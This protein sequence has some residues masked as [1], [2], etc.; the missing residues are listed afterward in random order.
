MSQ[1]HYPTWALPPESSPFSTGFASGSPPVFSG[2]PS[3]F[4]SIVKF[5][6]IGPGSDDRLSRNRLGHK[7]SSHSGSPRRSG[8]PERGR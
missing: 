5:P 1:Q 2:E 6:A 7:P 4:S 8:R 3:R